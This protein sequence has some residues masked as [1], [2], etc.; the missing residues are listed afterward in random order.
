MAALCG[1]FSVG[2]ALYLRRRA[3]AA[4]R[5]E[6]VGWV[7]LCRVQ[8]HGPTEQPWDPG[9]RTSLQGGAPGGMKIATRMVLRS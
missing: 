1:G 3:D 8:L 6:H 7:P 4:F 5:Q 2:R 9:I